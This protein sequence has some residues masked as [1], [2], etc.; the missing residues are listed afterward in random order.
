MQPE[1]TYHGGLP[2]FLIYP[3]G[4]D[5]GFPMM[6]EAPED[7]DGPD[8]PRFMW[9]LLQKHDAKIVIYTATSR[10]GCLLAVAMTENVLYRMRCP[11]LP[12][13]GEYTLG[14]WSIDRHDAKE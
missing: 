9:G 1:A 14:D 11:I 2:G 10:S 13:R 12:Y 5:H 8:V 7:V 4:A 6:M 3:K